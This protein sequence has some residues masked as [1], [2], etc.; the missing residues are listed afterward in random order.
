MRLESQ[1]EKGCFLKALA[2]AVIALLL[3]LRD[4]VYRAATKPVMAAMEVSKQTGISVS[5]DAGRTLGTLP[6]LFRAGVFTA[7][8]VPPEPVQKELLGELRPGSIEIALGEILKFSKDMDDALHLLAWMDPFL[9]KVKA[10]G[11]EVVLGFDMVPQWLSSRPEDRTTFGPSATPVSILS[12]PRDYEEWAKFIEAIVTHF[13]KSVGVDVRYKIGWEPDWGWQGSEEEFFKLYRYSVLGARRADPRA[14]VGGPGVSDI[15]PFWKKP[16]DSAPMLQRFIE[17]CGRTAIP[18]LGLSRL[19]IDFVAIHR[20]GGNPLTTYSV[21]VEMI[22]GW[23]REQGYSPETEIYIGEW[24]DRPDPF[25]PDRDQPYLASFIVANL[26]GMDRAGIDRQSFTSLMEQQVKEETQFSGG[27]GLFTKNFLPRPS[28]YAFKALSEL[29]QTRLQMVSAD[30]WVLGV[31]GR[32]PNRVALVVTHYIPTSRVLFRMFGEKLLQKGYRPSDFAPYFKSREALEQILRG[33][34]APSYFKVPARMEADILAV[35]SE[36]NALAKQSSEGAKTAT[37]INVEFKELSWLGPF[38]LREYRIDSQSSNPIRFQK[39]IDRRTRERK[40]EIEQELER[41]RDLLLAE[42]GYSKP[43]AQRFRSYLGSRDKR[44]FLEQ[45][46]RP[47]REKLF[48]II[49]Y[50]GSHFEDRVGRMA[51]EIKKRLD[52]RFQQVTDRPMSAT[53]RLGFTLELEPWAVSLIILEKRASASLD[54]PG[55]TR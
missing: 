28:F 24:S 48:E 38:V 9:G 22:S 40:K 33:E 54:A 39:E 10:H 47:E 55:P 41:E 2:M 17:Y 43:E 15:G 7:S 29:G 13:N 6:F 5:V 35:R 51:E 19:P 26:V 36:L 16:P 3:P 11:G 45:L 30:P 46:P 49:R 53:N 4:A 42:K 52:I 27:F 31:A 8:P 23:L 32:E 20:F 12:A 34:K 37:K 18:E 50:M 44:A 14:R 25:S 1:K 21:L